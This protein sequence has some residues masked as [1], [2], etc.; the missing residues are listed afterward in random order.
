MK[1]VLSY[2]NFD[3]YGEMRREDFCQALDVCLTQTGRPKRMIKEIIWSLFE[4]MGLIVNSNLNRRN[5]SIWYEP[6]K[7]I[8]M[9]LLSIIFGGEYESIGEMINDLIHFYD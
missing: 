8:Y 6:I 9:L 4:K 7:V 5:L 1:F 3:E 2:F